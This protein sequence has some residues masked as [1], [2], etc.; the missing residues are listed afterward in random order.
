MAEGRPRIQAAYLA[1]A[2]ARKSRST[3]P[4]ALDDGAVVVDYDS[5]TGAL[6]GL[7]MLDLR[8]SS[9]ELPELAR[10]I[11]KTRNAL[12][13]CMISTMTLQWLVVERVLTALAALDGQALRSLAGNTQMQRRIARATL[14]D[15]PTW[16]G[17]GSGSTHRVAALTAGW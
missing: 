12:L 14:G 3:D 11:A 2:D 15:K 7:E 17:S 5:E 13:L 10:H 16:H 6:A 9:A 8:A 4:L 1:I